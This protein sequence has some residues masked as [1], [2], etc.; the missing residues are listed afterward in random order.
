ME[1]LPFQNS[2]LR[3]RATTHYW[4][5]HISAQGGDGAARAALAG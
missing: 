5:S 2:P 1:L 4:A 3:A